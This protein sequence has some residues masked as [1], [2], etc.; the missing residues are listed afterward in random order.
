MIEL[1]HTNKRSQ[2]G[3]VLVSSLLLL[4]VVTIMALSIFRSFGLQER[5]AGNTRD[6]QRALQVAT[7]VQQYAE[8]WIANSSGAPVAVATGIASSADYLCAAASGT[9]ASSMATAPQICT[10]TLASLGAT[11]TNAPWVNGTGQ[12][13]GVQYTPPGL[14]VSPTLVTGSVTND[15]YFNQPAFYITDLGAPAGSLVP[16]AGS[17]GEVYKIDAYGSGVS[18][19]T[20]AVVESTLVVSCTVC[21]LGAI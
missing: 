20:I 12:Y 7:S 5:I 6:K 1:P 8:S 15:L 11:V 18:P 9:L 19:N 3:I 21:N 14:S 10:N 2:S 17:K 4:L 13:I 16:G